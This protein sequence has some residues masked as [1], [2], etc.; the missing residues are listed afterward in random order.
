MAIHAFYT[1]D[2]AVSTWRSDWNAGWRS[3][4]FFNVRV[5]PI[6]H[7]SFRLRPQSVRIR[8]IFE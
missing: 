3:L 6:A 4:W 2:S 5:M 1:L 8:A 7:T